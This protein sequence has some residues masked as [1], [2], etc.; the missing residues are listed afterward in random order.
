MKG[1]ERLAIQPSNVYQKRNC[2]SFHPLPAWWRG[3]LFKVLRPEELVVYLY[4]CSF[5]GQESVTYPSME[6]MAGSLSFRSRSSIS[7]IIK[8]LAA[9][10]FI[11]YEKK[12]IRERNTTA[13]NVYQIPSQEYTLLTLLKKKK[14]GRN[15]RAVARRGDPPSPQYLTI[16]QKS[17]N[18]VVENGLSAL[19]GAEYK[20]FEKVGTQSALV[21]ALEKRLSE[22]MGIPKKRRPRKAALE[23]SDAQIT[24]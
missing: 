21:S 4:I 9:L 22:R 8:S 24:T 23:T 20:N 10:G 13:R 11:L 18:G 6:H 5:A 14:I 12:P 1:D 17:D 2:G 15:L 7:K 3:F 16:E 19:L